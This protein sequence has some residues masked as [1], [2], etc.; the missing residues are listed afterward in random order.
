M[1][2]RVTGFSPDFA[3]PAS[4]GISIP[5]IRT[6]PTPIIAA[7]MCDSGARSPEAPTEPCAG[8]TGSTPRSSIVVS[9]RTV[10]TVTPE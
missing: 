10:A 6:V 5:S 4:A 1:A 2:P 9:R 8:T 3:R 7:V